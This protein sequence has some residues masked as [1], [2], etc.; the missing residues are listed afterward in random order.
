MAE[1]IAVEV[2][3]NDSIEKVWDAFTKPEHIIKWAFASDDWHAPRAENDLRAG[4]KFNT[5]MESKDGSEGFDFAG[6]YD[7]VVPRQRIAYTMDDG[8]IATVVFEEMGNSTYI[9]T[10]FDSES[11]NP[12]EMQKEGW[13][14]IL[15]NFKKYVEVL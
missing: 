13:Q 4:G 15:D 7:E 5:R 6:T 11:E 14:G 12:I 3:I 2:I 9:K 8:R 10:I 1:K